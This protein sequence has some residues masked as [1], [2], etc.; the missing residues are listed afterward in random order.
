MSQRRYATYQRA[1]LW[2]RLV[3]RLRRGTL[4]AD[5]AWRGDP[6][7]IRLVHEHRGWV[8]RWAEPSQEASRHYGHAGLDGLLEWARSKHGNR[9]AAVTASV[10]ADPRLESSTVAARNEPTP[11]TWVEI[12]C[13]DPAPLLGAAHEFFGPGGWVEQPGGDPVYVTR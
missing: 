10:G 9:I 12:V 5:D 8:L 4:E 6:D 2:Q 7:K 1:S 11:R 3:S 13:S